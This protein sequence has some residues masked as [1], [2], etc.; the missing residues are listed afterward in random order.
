MKAGKGAVE[1]PMLLVAAKDDRT[2]GE[3]QKW[4]W[5]AGSVQE[6]PNTRRVK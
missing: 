1:K 6:N 3:R 2:R 5:D 4:S